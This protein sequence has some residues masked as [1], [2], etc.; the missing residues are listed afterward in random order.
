MA[1]SDVP[2]TGRAGRPLRQ[3]AAAN[4]RRLLVAAAEVFAEQGPQAK[5]ADVAHRAGV[6]MGTVYRNFPT[7]DALIAELFRER[8]APGATKAT[9]ADDPPVRRDA[10][11]NRRRILEAAAQVFAAH[12]LEVKVGEVADAAGLGL[13][14]LYRNFPTKQ[15]L[16]SELVR[17]LLCDLLAAAD[18]ALQEPDGRGLR[19][20]LYALGEIQS[21]RH[22]C[23]PRLWNTAEHAELMAA[24]Q[25][26]NAELL[27]DAQRHGRIRDDLTPGDVWVAVWSLR[28]VIETTRGVAPQAWRRH[29]DLMLAGMEP[30]ATPSAHGALAPA[31]VDQVLATLRADT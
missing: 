26:A 20:F 11:D 29:L 22:G 13:G 1:S 7:K 25:A 12:G 2:T 24:I 15:A 30:A 8:A 27:A 31:I 14:T 16:I 28:G 21:L 9:D 18:A 5:V 17:E 3:D 4:R 19:T 6:G 10:A 23:L